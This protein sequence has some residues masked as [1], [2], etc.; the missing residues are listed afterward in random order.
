MLGETLRSNV[1][2][3]DNG[4]DASWS[5]APPLLLS[6]DK[7][8]ST[9]YYLRLFHDAPYYVGDGEEM[10]D[11]WLSGEGINWAKRYV[12]GDIEVI[13]RL[14]IEG[15]GKVADL[16]FFAVPHVRKHRAPGWKLLRPNLGVGALQP[17][18]GQKAMLAAV[19]EFVENPDS[20]AP[21]PS[22]IRLERP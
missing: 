6:R 8:G 16:V 20:A 18:A 10:R 19:T 15:S 21:L 2:Q 12:E 4:G 7:P 3:F 17:Y 5:G 9:G 22:L 13:L 1:E 11:R 14:S